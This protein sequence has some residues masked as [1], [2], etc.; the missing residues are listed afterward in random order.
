MKKYETDSIGN[1][2]KQ[3]SQNDVYLPAIQRKFVWKYDQIEMLFDSIMRDINRHISFLLVKGDTKDDYTF[4]KFIQEYHERDNYLNEVAPKPELKEK[5]TGVLDGQQRLSSMYIALQGTYAYKK[6]YF[7]VE[8]D[9]AY[10]KRE[11]YLNLLSSNNITEGLLYEFKFLED[12][13]GKILDPNQ[14]YFRFKENQLWFKVKE[15]LKWGEDPEID[16]Y[17]DNLIDNSDLYPI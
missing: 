1:L 8:S 10:P 12:E 17:Y 4:Y 16:K 3:I 15:V 14:P 9:K 6:K 2:M 5:I 7:R 13:F 11:M